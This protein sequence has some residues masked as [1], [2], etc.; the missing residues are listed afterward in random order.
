MVRSAFVAIVVALTFVASAEAGPVKY[1]GKKIA[2]CSVVKAVAKGSSAVAIGVA[3]GAAAVGK[4]TVKV[5]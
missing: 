5:L 4:K 2:K 1:A 3:K